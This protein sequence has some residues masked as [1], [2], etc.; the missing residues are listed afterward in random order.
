MTI[1][2]K[3]E[4]KLYAN[5]TNKCPCACVFCIRKNSDSIMGNDSLWLEHEPDYDEIIAAFEAF[6]KTGIT[7]L[8]FC[9]YGEPMSRS[10]MLLKVAR[11]VKEHTQMKI[12]INTN[13]LVDF[14]NP[15]FDVYSMRYIIDSISISLNAPD[16]ESYLAVTRPSFGL[17]SFNSMINFA[18]LAKSVVPEV[19]FTVVDVISEQ[20]IEECKK[21]S[22]N[23]E[24]PLRIRH[25]VTD[26]ESY[27]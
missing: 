4:G 22:E 26:N 18:Q 24:I 11:Y 21:L 2:Y 17:P 3:F 27:T 6:D 14:I 16:P 13:G 25:Y 10:D 7:D 19:S 9:G 1:F 23:L 5:I 12:R 20:Q 8:V 15:A